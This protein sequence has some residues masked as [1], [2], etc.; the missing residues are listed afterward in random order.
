MKFDTARVKHAAAAEARLDLVSSSLSLARNASEALEEHYFR[1]EFMRFTFKGQSRGR[2]MFRAVCDDVAAVLA[3]LEGLSAGFVQRRAGGKNFFERGA[4]CVIL[5]RKKNA[6]A[7]DSADDSPDALPPIVDYEWRVVLSDVVVSWR[8]A[9]ALVRECRGETMRRAQVTVPFFGALPYGGQRWRVLAWGDDA[10]N[11]NSLQELIAAKGEVA[12]EAALCGVPYVRTAA[13]RGSLLRERLELV[14]DEAA[15]AAY[16][17]AR[18]SYVKDSVCFVGCSRVFIGDPAAVWRRGQRM[19]VLGDHWLVNEATGDFVVTYMKGKLGVTNSGGETFDFIRS[20]TRVCTKKTLDAEWLEVGTHPLHVERDNL[21]VAVPLNA[22]VDRTSLLDVALV[23]AEWVSDAVYEQWVNSGVQRVSQM[24]FALPYAP[25]WDERCATMMLLTE[26]DSVE[27]LARLHPQLQCVG[28]HLEDKQEQRLCGTV[29]GTRSLCVD[30]ASAFGDYLGAAMRCRSTEDQGDDFACDDYMKLDYDSGELHCVAVAATACEQVLFK[31]AAQ[32]FGRDYARR[33]ETDCSKFAETHFKHGV[34]I[35]VFVDAMRACQGSIGIE[36]PMLHARSRAFRSVVLYDALDEPPPVPFELDD[37]DNDYHAS[38]ML[39]GTGLCP[40]DRDEDGV[41]RVQVPAEVHQGSRKTKLERALDFQKA[42]ALTHGIELQYELSLMQTAPGA[43]LEPGALHVCRPWPLAPDGSG[44]VQKPADHIGLDLNVVTAQPGGGKT[45]AATHMAMQALA[46][47]YDSV[48]IVTARDNL[49]DQAVFQTAQ[50]LEKAAF[51]YFAVGL[52]EQAELYEREVIDLRHTDS[53][54][55]RDHMCGANSMPALMVVTL[56]SLKKAVMQIDKFRDLYRNVLLIIDEWSTML[57]DYKTILRIPSAEVPLQTLLADRESPVRQVVVLDAKLP[58]YPVMTLVRRLVDYAHRQPI[59]Q[60]QQGMRCA[61][62]RV[63]MRVYDIQ[64]NPVTEQNRECVA[65]VNHGATN[66]LQAQMVAQLRR[67]ENVAAFF[68]SAAKLRDFRSMLSKDRVVQDSQIFAYYAE[69]KTPLKDFARSV[70]QYR[71]LLYTTALGVGTDINPR[72]VA[73]N[74]IKHFSTVYMFGAKEAYVDVRQVVSRVRTFDTL[75]LGIDLAGGRRGM[76]ELARSQ[77]WKDA[78]VC[79]NIAG[80]AEDIQSRKKYAAQVNQ[81]LEA[82][83]NGFRSIR[84]FMS[85]EEA[86][87]RMPS[88]LIDIALCHAL[89]LDTVTHA[90]MQI[91]VVARMG[92]RTRIV[93]GDKNVTQPQRDTRKRKLDAASVHLAGEDCLEKKHLVSA[94]ER[95]A[96]GLSYPTP[97]HVVCYGWELRYRDWQPSS[98]RIAYA[99]T[100]LTARLHEAAAS[101]GGV[102]AVDFWKEAQGLLLTEFQHEARVEKERERWRVAFKVGED[103]SGK[104]L[105]DRDLLAYHAAH[106]NGQRALMKAVSLFC[107]Q[108]ALVKG[109]LSLLEEGGALLETFG[110]RGEGNGRAT[111]GVKLPL[112][113]DFIGVNNT[114]SCRMT[115]TDDFEAWTDDVRGLYYKK[116]KAKKAHFSAVVPGECV[117]DSPL[118]LYKS[119]LRRLFEHSFEPKAFSRRR[120]VWKARFDVLPMQNAVLEYARARC[121]PPANPNEVRPPP[122]LSS[123]QIDALHQSCTSLQ[124]AELRLR[125]ENAQW[126]ANNDKDAPIPGAKA[127]YGKKR[128]ETVAERAEFLHNEAVAPQVVAAVSLAREIYQLREERT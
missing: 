15:N 102:V 53:N 2:S 69:E 44:D 67:G 83:R 84:D 108:L 29:V 34:P 38:D 80:L 121:A 66:L 81:L 42:Q 36:Y 91:D 49:V 112:M 98:V 52:D 93:A 28:L 99:V 37:R 26:N 48:L 76:C 100:A 70:R 50:A 10:V 8:V 73:G 104:A 87:H 77:R 61:K 116:T 20:H 6:S 27:E 107:S 59:A 21:A 119:H 117:N 55:T 57:V 64:K 18:A 1:P 71:V 125:A 72:D 3:E 105:V 65:Y 30:P 115:L 96:L 103:A 7:D 43:Y 126:E 128:K 56:H 41:L 122:M 35:A 46:E 74:P 40:E 54:T 16:A 9:D 63:N 118:F 86:A 120:G 11:A 47:G 51:G 82:G 25:V 45:T 89:H 23:T 124:A 62:V 95:L 109:D 75:V 106:G 31:D 5:A 24:R 111:A 33:A 114:N 32:T 13:A 101:D 78:V 14:R 68:S 79:S 127:G 113:S 17:R 39:G 60:R 110:H 90:H 92:Y 12:V 97:Q 85:R 88:F 123:A 94:S 19:T 4:H 22:P 58:A